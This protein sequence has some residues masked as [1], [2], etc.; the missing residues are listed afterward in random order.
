[1]ADQLSAPEAGAS[2]AARLTI[3]SLP[4]SLQCEVFA[5]TPVDARAACAAVCKGWHN[6]LADASLWTRLDLSPASGVSDERV[7]DALLRGAA[8]KAQGVLTALDVSDCEQLAHDVLLELIVANAGALTELRACRG[9]SQT[10]AE[11]I[12]AL[13]RAAPLLRVFDVDV[14]DAAA[15]VARR[16]LRNEPPFGPLR[17]HTLAVM[18]P[19]PGG[20]VDVRAF[21]ADL[22]ASAS[23]LSH[24]VL[25]S[26]PLAGQGALDAVVHAALARRLPT[27]GLARCSLSAASMPAVVRLLSGTALKTLSIMQDIHAEPL[28]VSGAEGS[29][30]L[31]A[32]ALRANNTLTSLC[33]LYS[34]VWHDIQAAETLLQA[35]TAHTSVRSLWLEGNAVRDADHA[36]A[37]VSLGAL[38]AAHALALKTLTVSFCALGDEGLGPLVDAL[39]TNTH[40]RELHCSGNGMS[41]AFV[42]ERLQPALV[43]NMTLR[44]LVLAEAG[45]NEEAGNVILPV[46]RQLEQLVAAERAAKRETMTEHAQ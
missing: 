40:L 43:A 1:M 7:T 45:E 41:D 4:P 31:L 29:A 30:A 33:L 6:T 24:L 34:K 44:Q 35:L 36:R 46:M 2:Q 28:L 10:T 14:K 26:A 3:A 37:G 15:A 23:L 25:W 22:T 16:M 17:L 27:L 21:A 39:A 19:W 5:R 20:E 38:I 9:W 12:E 13:L 42:R 18:A 32:A 8:G 11:Q